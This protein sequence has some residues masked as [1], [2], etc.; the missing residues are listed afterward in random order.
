MKT[1]PT[2]KALPNSKMIA[3]RFARFADARR[4]VAWIHKM[5]ADGK[6]VMVSTYT[7]STCYT[8]KHAGMFRASKSGAFVQTGR[9]WDCIDF[10]KLTAF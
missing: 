7:K 6:S 2:A 5:L 3:N 9:R 8:A 1:T 4:K 10:C